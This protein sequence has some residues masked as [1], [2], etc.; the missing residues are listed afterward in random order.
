[1]RHLLGLSSYRNLIAWVLYDAW[2]HLHDRD[3][4]GEESV[5]LL[6]TYGEA[7][8]F[9]L[10][11]VNHVETAVSLASIL[12]DDISVI[13]LWSSEQLVEEVRNG[14]ASLLETLKTLCVV[15][16]EDVLETAAFEP[17]LVRL[18]SLQYFHVDRAADGL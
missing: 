4:I 14:R 12:P 3:R 11:G 5:L 8:I 13:R 7:C 16:T 9:C 1:M 15:P 2:I 6:E 18:L 17:Q 10:R